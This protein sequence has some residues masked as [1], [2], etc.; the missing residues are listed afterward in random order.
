MNHKTRIVVLRMKE[1]V[2]SGI[3]ALLGI[4]FLVLLIIMFVPKKEDAATE[5]PPPSVSE[6]RYIPGIYTTSITLGDQVVDIEVLVDE[7][8]INSIELTNLSEE[9]ETLYP[10]V[11]PSLEDLS[12]QIISN[13]SLDDITYSDHSKYT[14]MVLLEAVKISLEK[15]E[16]NHP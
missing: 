2:Y 15:A 7:N 3:F 5:L 14:S 9:V 16:N 8:N 13:Q 6:A 12:A 11:K 4:L 10:L 1:I